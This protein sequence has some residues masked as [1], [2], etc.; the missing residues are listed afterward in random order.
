MTTSFNLTRNQIIHKAYRKAGVLGEGETLEAWQLEEAADDLNL[1][2][3]G[4]EKHRKKL[5]AIETVVIPITEVSRVSYGGLN[6]R[7]TY[8]HTS[9]AVIIPTNTDYWEEIE[10]TDTLDAWA[11]DTSYQGSSFASSEGMT[12]VEQATVKESDQITEVTLLNRFQNATIPD[13]TETGIISELHFERYPG[14]IT[15][16]PIPDRDMTLTLRYIRLL[17]DITGAGEFPDVP[18]TL[19]AY[20]IYE[21]AAEIAEESDRE[22]EKI[23]RLRNKAQAELALAIR[24][25]KEY[26]DMDFIAPA[27]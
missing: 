18:V 21:L 4:L 20:L 22:A 16:N 13:R 8:S 25:Q 24:N 11:E 14:R 6:Y 19:L 12:A 15:L 5:W 1:I 2:I 23:N 7:C 9:T 10:T 17:G 26:S 27:Y 3:K